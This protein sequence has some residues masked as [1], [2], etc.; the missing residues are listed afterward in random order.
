MANSTGLGPIS[1]T[2]I[3]DRMR[4]WRDHMQLLWTP[5]MRCDSAN[6]GQMSAEQLGAIFLDQGAATDWVRHQH[7][8]E[9]LALPDFTGGVNRGD[10]QAVYY[11]VRKLRPSSILEIGTHVG[12]SLVNMSL[13]AK[14][15]IRED[16]AHNA[17]LTTVDIVDVNDTKSRPWVAHGARSSPKEMIGQIGCAELVTFHVADSVEFLRAT[18]QSFDFIF[19]DGLHEARQVYREIPLALSRL[20]AGGFILLHDYFPGLRPLWS[21]GYVIC[22]P[23]M[24]VNRLIK[25]GANLKVLPLGELPWPTKLDSRVTSLALVARR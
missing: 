2:R 21:N 17:R 13:A 5:L 20:N 14:D 4:A 23:V 12:C 1:V 8:L 19:L 11:L 9:D 10:Q 15:C 16:S 22:G 3:K 24:G 7:L 18:H 6:L 25:E